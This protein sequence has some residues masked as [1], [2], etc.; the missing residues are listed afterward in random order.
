MAATVATTEMIRAS[1]A[2]VG[3]CFLNKR[4]GGAQIRHLI[5]Q[6]GSLPGCRVI[7]W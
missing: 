4:A 7:G 3:K 5:E 6:S 2:S 1:P